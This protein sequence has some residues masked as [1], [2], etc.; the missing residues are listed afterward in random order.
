[1][2]T[3]N[4]QIIKEQQAKL[5]AELAERLYNISEPIN[6]PQSDNPILRALIDASESLNGS[7]AQ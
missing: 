2:R 4:E 7:E 1:M 6:A 3:P 5:R